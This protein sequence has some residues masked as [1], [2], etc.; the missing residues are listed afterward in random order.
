MRRVDPV[1][2]DK[3]RQVLVSA[4]ARGAD[5]ATALD[6]AG[7]LDHPGKQREAAINFMGLLI[8]SLDQINAD[9]MGIT[10][11]PKT[12]LDLKRWVMNYIKGIQE[13]LMR[14]DQ[15]DQ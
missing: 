12:P 8:A 10:S 4:R 14:N 5:P 7:L 6:Q 11:V 2:A 3:V 1:T 13:G 15:K 9:L